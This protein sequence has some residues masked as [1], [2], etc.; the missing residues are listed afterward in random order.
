MG[1]LTLNIKSVKEFQAGI[2]CAYLR[3]YWEYATSCLNYTGDPGQKGSVYLFSNL[4]NKKVAVTFLLF[5]KS[6]KTNDYFSL[7]LKR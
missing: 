1:I 2:K 5:K 6:L 4:T 3:R 7:P